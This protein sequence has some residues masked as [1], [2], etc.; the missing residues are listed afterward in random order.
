MFL[1]FSSDLKYVPNFSTLSI[2]ADDTKVYGGG[3]SI[4]DCE[5]LQKDMMGSKWA[6]SWQLKLNPDKTKHLQIGKCKCDFP[7]QLDG[8]Y[9][10]K[11][12]SICDIGV[13]IQSNLKFSSLPQCC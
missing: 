2:Y 10:E 8:K 7:Y 9:Y 1:C 13:Y 6:Q 11:V 3:N 12:S 5:L 4:D